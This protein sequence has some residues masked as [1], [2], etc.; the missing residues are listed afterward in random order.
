MG[1][2]DSPLLINLILIVTGL[3][4]GSFATALAHRVPLRKSVGLKDFS[5]R[6][7]CPHCNHALRA[8]DLVP[9]LSWVSTGGVCRYCKKPVSIGYPLMELGVLV[10]CL[11]PYWVKGFT[12]DTFFIISAVPFLAALLVI[13]LRHM[14]LPNNLLLALAALGLGRTVYH[15]TLGD[16]PT[17]AQI[18]EFVTS[19][20]IFAGFS[21]LIGF[22][23]EKILKKEALGMGDVKF[24]ALS[25]L[26]L[27]LSQLGW[28]CTLSGLLG[29]LFAAIF[30]RNAY[31]NGNGG[32]FP[33]GPA[34][35][36]ALY[37]LLLTDGSLF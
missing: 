28:Y 21:W 7:A 9:V 36:A 30:R 17:G 14:I 22:V 25:G 2:E 1:L 29:V 5:T 3:T 37:I 12:P 23:M 33:F 4:L 18:I 35:I 6:S 26:W 20:A 11:V 10:A 34:L 19:I 13:D 16:A 24:F 27:G 15:V 8:I 32:A 31:K